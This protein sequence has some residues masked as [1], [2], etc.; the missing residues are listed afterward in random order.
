MILLRFAV[1]GGPFAP[2]RFT[3]KM[4]ERL[5]FRLKNITKVFYMKRILSGTILTVIAC[6][7]SVL[8]SQ[9]QSPGTMLGL[10]ADVSG[11]VSVASSQSRGLSHSDLYDQHRYLLALLHELLLEAG[12]HDGT[13]QPAR[14]C[15]PTR[16][17]VKRVAHQYFPADHCTNEFLNP[18]TVTDARNAE[19][20]FAENPACDQLAALFP[21]RCGIYSLSLSE[22][23]NQ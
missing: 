22:S 20:T 1:Q 14:F 2:H 11:A 9:A 16:W 7:I 18:T 19:R 4:A 13:R 23:A 21:S 6:V 5:R 17:S 10:S 3:L 12:L 8:N 15:A